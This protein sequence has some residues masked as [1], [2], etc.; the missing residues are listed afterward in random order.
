MKRILL[1]AVMAGCSSSPAPQTGPITG[2]IDHDTTWSG[3]LELHGFVTIP[4][5][6]TVTV[7]PGT[8]I[9]V[10][11]G[12]AIDVA[13]TLDIAG[14]KDAVV[15][16]ATASDF[17]L[18]VQVQGTYIMHYGVQRGGGIAT[19]ADTASITITDSVLSDAIGDYLVMGGGSIDVEY[20]NLGLETGDHSHC[21]IHV[22]AGDHITF[23]HSTNGGSSFGLMFYAGTGDFSDDNWIG[24][25]TDIEPEA[26][27][28]GTFNGG[29]FPAGTPAGIQG[30]T[31]ADL[32]ATRRTDTGPR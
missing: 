21:N 25:F 30:S 4:E 15:T 32:S 19:T 24:N 7:A 26:T 27:G 2:V 8:T 22:N 12:A 28:T 29:Y 9:D 16:L 5:G 23:T 13:G 6:V 18:G 17:W 14:D 31:F 11:T 1:A 3:D 20:T 10:A